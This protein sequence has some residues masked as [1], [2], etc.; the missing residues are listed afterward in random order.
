M[1][2][3]ALWIKKTNSYAENDCKLRTKE[4]PAKR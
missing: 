1:Q 2:L 4:A 3:H